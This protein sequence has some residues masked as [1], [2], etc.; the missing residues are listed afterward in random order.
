MTVM[1]LLIEIPP[2]S[3]A[4]ESRDWMVSMRTNCG[5]MQVNI[6]AAR[7]KP[8][9]RLVQTAG[10][11]AAMTMTARPA[12]F[13]YSC[14]LQCVRYQP[15]MGISTSSLWAIAAGVAEIHS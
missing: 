11:F 6:R 8:A 2:R 4:G 5:L 1:M 15:T 9:R 10:L 14:S 3:V 7:I 12:S 13:C